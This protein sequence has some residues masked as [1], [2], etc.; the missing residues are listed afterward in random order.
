MT[1]DTS[2]IALVRLFFERIS[3]DRFDDA[4]DLLAEDVFYHNIPL[5]EITGR[6]N[7][8]S[9]HKTFGVGSRIRVEWQLL[10]IAQ[11]GDTVL[12]ERLDFFTGGNGNRITLPT[13]GSMRVNDGVIT[14]WRD[15]F[16][17]ISFERQAAALED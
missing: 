13:M 5:P 15:Y 14:E 1:E 4:I 3:A 17:L 9:F 2:E 8:R 6:E 7:A 16:D 12:T 11:D 10:R